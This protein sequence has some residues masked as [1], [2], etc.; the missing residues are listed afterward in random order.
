MAPP[1]GRHT[2][3][4]EYPLHLVIGGADYT[5]LLT[6]SFTFSN[7]DPG[8]YEMAS[9]AIG[10]DLPMLTRGMPVRLDCGTQV[11]WEGR[12]K[13]IQRSLGHKTLVQCEGYGAILRENTT[14]EIF[15]D[16]DLTKW[17]GPS[18]ERSIALVTANDSPATPTAT[19]EPGSG[20]PALEALLTGAWEATGLPIV[21][22]WYNAQGLPIAAIY[23]DW[24]KGG[25]VI[26]TDP[27]W[28]WAVYLS[29]DSITTELDSSGNLRAAT[30]TPTYFSTVKENRKF[31]LLQFYYAVAGGAPNVPYQ[32]FWKKLAVYGRGFNQFIKGPESDSE[33]IEPNPVGYYPSTIVRFVVK[34][35]PGIQPGVIE[36]A[37]QYVVPH[38]VYQS[39]VENQKIIA[40]MANLI[41]VHWGVWESLN[42]LTTPN[43]EP[44]LD[45]RSYPTLG[46]PTAWAWRRECESLDIRED[47]S[48]Q[49][50][51]AKVTYTEAAG[52]AGVVTVTVPNPILEAAG[53]PD[54][55]L[56][57]TL[58]TS[59]KAAAEAY[60][61]IALELLQD[62]ARVVGSATVKE[63]IHRIGGGETAPWLL[64]SGIDRL[65][66]PDLPSFDVWGIYNDLPISRVECSG[67]ADG[68]STSIEFGLGPNLMET[69]TA[70][71]QQS[72]VLAMVGG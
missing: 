1:K 44:R 34:E 51:T 18:V 25:K 50:N 15:V 27:N 12:I 24:T 13:E 72:A 39:P 66:I 65:R 45:F 26:Q 46:N 41:S 48:S 40:D 31:A 29:S 58:G 47:L 4:E 53:I 37:T 36:K 35:T 19:P 61:I 5:F 59:T 16:R 9:F 6:D 17:Q 43:P 60:G 22:A 21:E 28:N 54:R 63:P 49:Y 33:G 62:Q 56:P 3:R 30:S 2:V 14:A 52:N 8:G 71:L 55:T 23:Y 67:G 68:Y 20:T 7:V 42:C 10:K 38:A 70:R 69:L 64:K 11:A 57:L 32:I